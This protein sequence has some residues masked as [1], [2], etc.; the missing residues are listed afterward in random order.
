[1]SILDKNYLSIRILP[2][3]VDVLVRMGEKTTYA[4]FETN[5]PKGEWNLPSGMKQWEGMAFEKVTCS[6]DNEFFGLVPAA[7]FDPLGVEHYLALSLTSDS[8]RYTCLYDQFSVADMMVVY[9]VDRL[10]YHAIVNAFPSAVFRHYSSICSPHFLRHAPR[11]DNVVYVHMCPGAFYLVLKSGGKMKVCNR[12]VYRAP[13]D[14]LYYLLFALEQAG[15]DPAATTLV[16]GGE[17]QKNMDALMLLK[18]FFALVELDEVKEQSSE[19]M[20]Y[21]GAFASQYLCV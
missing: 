6:V 1:M 8:S 18:E 15:C 19:E 7:V 10:M 5:S 3:R 2:Q 21:Q 9:A 11:A 16:M 17:V 20:K 14:I 12:F 4:Q 13:E